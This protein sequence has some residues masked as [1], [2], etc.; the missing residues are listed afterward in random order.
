MSDK[1]L[2]AATERAWGRKGRLQKILRD[3]ALAHK[4]K[5][6]MV[7]PRDPAGTVRLAE[8]PDLEGPEAVPRLRDLTLL[9]EAG[10]MVE[11]DELHGLGGQVH[12]AKRSFL[13]VGPKAQ[14]EEME[15]LRQN[16]S[17]ADR[18]FEEAVKQAEEYRRDRSGA[19]GAIRKALDRVVGAPRD[20]ETLSEFVL[21]RT[22]RKD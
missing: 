8:S 17:F 14:K 22:G 2:Q 18:D 9:H 16:P 20:D 5:A 7:D 4:G 15:R 21:R 19:L 6:G 10:H 3:A 12:A 13:G 1:E 11:R